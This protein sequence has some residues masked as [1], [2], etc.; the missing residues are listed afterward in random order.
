M[1]QESSVITPARVYCV[2][3]GIQ[4]MAHKLYGTCIYISKHHFHIGLNNSCKYH[5]QLTTWLKTCDYQVKNVSHSKKHGTTWRHVGRTITYLIVQPRDRH[6]D[7]PTD[8]HREICRDRP[9]DTP[10]DRPSDKPGKYPGIDAEIDPGID[11][12]ITTGRDV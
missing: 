4:H 1:K 6:S 11:P 8:K 7:R 2:T 3:V 5:K 12:G 9:S 10:R